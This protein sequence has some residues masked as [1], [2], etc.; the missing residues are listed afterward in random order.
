[1]ADKILTCRECG[2][3][4]VFTD[5]EQRFYLSRG[6]THEPRRCPACRGTRRRG[7]FKIICSSCGQEAEVSFEPRQGRPVY[8]DSCYSRMRR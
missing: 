8:C 2:Q 6:L 7:S 5:G 4:F 1:M 3:S